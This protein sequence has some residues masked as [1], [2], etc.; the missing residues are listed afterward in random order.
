MFCSHPTAALSH[1]LIRVTQGI[2]EHP[3]THRALHLDRGWEQR[4][5]EA[6]RSSGGCSVAE[7]SNI[8]SFSTAR[9]KYHL[10]MCYSSLLVLFHKSVECR[11][12]SDTGMAVVNRFEFFFPWQAKAMLLIKEG[13]V[14]I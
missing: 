11:I 5:C 3:C 8:I 9:I 6:R 10:E 2:Q 13:R 14:S 7:N 4:W 12:T 1:G